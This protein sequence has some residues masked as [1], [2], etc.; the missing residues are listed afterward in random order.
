MRLLLI[1]AVCFCTP[2]IAQE[3]QPEP[4]MQELLTKAASAKSEADFDA[5]LRAL[6]DAVSDK[7]EI[8]KQVAIFATGPNERSRQA[9]SQMLQRLK[10]S[11]RVVIR[12]LAP[13]LDSKDAKLRSFVRDWFSQHDKAGTDDPL[14]PVNYAD[15]VDYVRSYP[16]PP[17]PFVERIFGRSPERAFLVFY[18]ASKR[19]HAI[20]ALQAEA[21]E[22]AAARK[23][24]GVAALPAKASD[25]DELLLAELLVSNAIRLKRYDEQFQAALPEA[26]EQLTK[27]SKRDEWWARLYVAEIMRQQPELRVDDVLSNLS[28]DENELVSKRAQGLNE[29]PR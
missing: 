25:P 3:L 10:L 17:A 5:E 7:G 14:K 22:V 20:N 19:S 13:H 18:R 29:N 2:C 9:A 1:L 15:Y 24:A 8:V 6:D 16:D 21:R 11:P 26:K 12:T 23:E 27:L 4:P 28:N